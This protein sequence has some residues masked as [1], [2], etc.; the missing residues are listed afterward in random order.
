LVD[1]EIT[2]QKEVSKSNTE[3]PAQSGRDMVLLNA[4]YEGILIIDQADSITYCNKSLSDITGFTFEEML[5]SK[6]SEVVHN[7]DY[8]V[9]L[10]KIYKAKTGIKDCL[11]CRF[12][13][14]RKEYVWCGVSIAPVPDEISGYKGIIIIAHD[15]TG[16]KE[17]EKSYAESERRLKL[18]T[19][20]TS[21]IIS[22]HGVNGECK[23]IS[24]ACLRVLG[25]SQE[26][27]SGR[28]YIRLIHPHDFDKIIQA[29]RI[30]YS[31]PINITVTFRV[32]RKDETYVWCETTS[33]VLHD[34]N[35]NPVEIQSLTRDITERKLSE[36]QLSESLNSFLAV[37]ESTND[38]IWTVRADDF[39]LKTYNSSV[40]NFMLEAYGKDIEK[41][42]KIE[43]IF[44]AGKIKQWYNYYR[45]A[46]LNGPFSMEYEFERGY[47]IV[48]LTFHPI[49]SLGNNIDVLV[50]GKNITERINAQK[51]L[52]KSEQKFRLL[53]ENM[54]AGF[55]LFHVLFDSYNKAYNATVINVNQAFLEIF[56]TTE[57]DIKGKTIKCVNPHLK[58]NWMKTLG[59][60]AL[61]GNS[62]AFVDYIP[63]LGKHLDVR[64][65]R[66][67]DYHVAVI[68]TDVTEKK[69]VEIELNSYRM[70]LEDLIKERTK[71][72]EE[73]NSLLKAENEKVKAAEERV[74]VALAKEK[75][76]NE[77]KTRFISMTSH[78]FRT[79]LT[80]ILSS[81]D[82]LELYGKKWSEEKN[83]KHTTQIRRSVKYMIEL[84]EDVITIGH[85]ESGNVSFS[86]SKIRLKNLCREILENAR[87]KATEKHNFIFEFS[88]DDSEYL[89]DEKIINQMLTNILSNSVKYSPD[90]GNIIFC[91]YCRDGS[92]VF[93]FS[94]EGIGIASSEIKNL[95]SPFYRGRNVS[96]IPGTGL[97]LAIVKNCIELHSGALEI[98]SELNKGSLFTITIP[99]RR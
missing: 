95:T 35:G 82:L 51:A 1:K 55:G 64:I 97:G 19:D 9:F 44:P 49:V 33:R 90:G 84:L 52:E 39:S 57:A 93:K 70:R 40:R 92:I 43:N 8:E 77:L 28:K 37:I 29:F 61:S 27:L 12:F 83:K 85:V 15:I 86:P 88:G 73:V 3:N 38:I 80:A 46:L 23:F 91:V 75:E 69:K 71:E 22:F 26:E 98:E 14:K 87:L 13:S 94:D 48:A 2:M 78:E 68:I 4:S 99:L 10:E 60:A 6:I 50:F 59:E 16:Y 36:I 32:K 47:G 62:N 42:M 18:F 17:A 79:P 74:L 76:L 67:A 58:K 54:T 65:F 81:T 5:G 56:N 89:L 21:D 41:G 24:P 25:Y 11:E 96:T 66:H 53:F 20:N 34:E 31:K 30:G 7:T 45:N 63:S 72:L